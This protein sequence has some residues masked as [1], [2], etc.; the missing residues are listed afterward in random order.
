MRNLTFIILASFILGALNS[1]QDPEEKNPKI[2]EQKVEKVILDVNKKNVIIEDQQ[3]DD[4]LNRRNWKF[5][6]LPSGLRYKFLQK[7]NGLQVES[8]DQV[9]LDCKINLI[10]GELVFQSD[11]DGP[12]VFFVDQS[13]EISGLHEFVKHMHVGDVAKL[14]IPSYLAYGVT[15]DE[16]KIPARATLFM[17]VKLLRIKR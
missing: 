4:Y 3:I 6:R 8:G 13:E 15:G 14:V 16:K 9:Y 2:D 17:D 12:R 11:I 10:R 1:C 7:G 5:E